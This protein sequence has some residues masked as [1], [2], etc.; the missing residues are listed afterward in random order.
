M[1]C[2]NLTLKNLGRGYALQLYAWLSRFGP[3]LDPLTELDVIH[4]FYKEV[5]AGGSALNYGS[6]R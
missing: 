1:Q 5:E 6:R 2:S 3:Q 4:A